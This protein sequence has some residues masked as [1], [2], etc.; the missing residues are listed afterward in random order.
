MSNSSSWG[1]LLKLSTSLQ[2]GGVKGHF[3]QEDKDFGNSL[4]LV[5]I[6][7]ERS[8]TH[9]TG[10]WSE[11]LVRSTDGKTCLECPYYPY[12]D[13]TYPCQTKLVFTGIDSQLNILRVEF[14]EKNVYVGE[15]L[16]RALQVWDLNKIVVAIA[17]NAEGGL[18]AERSP[19]TPSKKQRDR[20]VALST[21]K[22]EKR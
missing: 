5:P 22:E 13:T 4:D 8:R 19:G 6:Q 17:A 10:C 9:A 21:D 3:Y 7:M 16:Y 1:S 15:A 14:S 12:T 11:D 18:T 20:A 2:G